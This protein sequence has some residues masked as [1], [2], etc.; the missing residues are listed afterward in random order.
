MVVAAI[1]ERSAIPK[2]QTWDSEVVFENAEA[3]NTEFDAVKAELP[4]LEKYKGRLSESPDTLAEFLKLSSELRRRVAKLYFYGAMNSAVDSANSTS[5][6]QVGQVQ[7]LWGIMGRA[8]AFA[9]PEMLQ[10]GEEQLMNWVT[11]TDSLK[12]YRQYVS[13]LFRQQ[14]HVLSSEVE[15]VL[16]MLNDPFGTARQIAGE[17]TNTDLEFEDAV[18]SDGN[19]VPVTQ[20]AI[21][22][23]KANIDR[24]VR[25]T[26]W[27]NYNNAHQKFK[28]TLATSYLT[29]VKQNT[30]MKNVR[31]FDDVLQMQLFPHNLPN[32]VF[33]NLIDT[34][35]KNLPTWHR[36][37]DVKR[38]ILGLDEM[39][40][41]DIWAP[42]TT[43]E[44]E[45]SYEQAVDYIVEGMKPLGEEYTTIMKR[46]CLEQR[47]VDYS[48]NKG[49]RQGAFSYGT[50][51]THPYIMMTFDNQ[52]S[53]MSTL[54]H[55]LGHS[56]HSL[57]SRANQ[58][59]HYSGYS[60]F[61]AETASNFNQAMTRAY[62]FEQENDRDFQLALIDE[63]MDNFHRYFFIMPTLA[64]FEYEVHSRVD[65]GK[66]ITADIL[67]GI[68]NEYF[69][70]GYG[71]T[72]KND[73]E[74][75]EI[76]WATFGHLYTAYYTF[77]YAT[78]ISAAHSLADKILTGSTSDARRYIR[79]LSAGSSQYPLEVL[80][81][82]GVDM[83]TPEPV[84]KTFEELTKLVD[85][86][87]G[88]IE[89]KS[90]DV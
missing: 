59:E 9:Q 21:R 65:A 35:K 77:Q 56:M 76:T 10:I 44:P 17:L 26:G 33:H 49:K 66:P 28:N 11:T 45:V 61:V 58:P 78:G 42:L 39:H 74:M 16:G 62:L 7:G 67:N 23:V 22:I 15:Q 85:R 31:G 1:P 18:D 8:T 54:A 86:L 37:W 57:L 2:E 90:D 29:S 80:K 63:A 24:T 38:R 30:M 19:K 14:K 12:T 48:V 6:E 32:D 81:N 4:K 75:T 72:L 53:G 52:L 82:A 60:M 79:F 51:D 84:E 20:G 25:E 36:Y 89:D 87:E 73:K 3:W 64:R 55:E 71:D 69:E 34:Y 5:K 50:Y 68:M 27:K 88:L 70:E 83:T 46:G 13:N 40:T 47:W 43:N 41:W